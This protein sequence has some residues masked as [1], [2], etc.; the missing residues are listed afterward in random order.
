MRE[1]RTEIDIDAPAEA[2]WSALMDFENYGAWNPFVREISGEPIPG[3]KLKVFIK[4]EGGSGMKL[5]PEVVTINE[6]KVFAWK[7]KLGISGIFDGKHEFIIE[8]KIDNSVRFIHREK[9]S[10]ILVPILWPMLE[11]NTRRG[12]E[13]MNK[14]LK[15]LVEGT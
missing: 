11:K 12:F 14:A 3:N 2:V 8:S 1:L 13:D 10:G 15:S 6:N 9:F 7:G 5:A 4:P